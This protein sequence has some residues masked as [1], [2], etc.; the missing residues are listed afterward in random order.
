MPPSLHLLKRF[1]NK[2]V[3]QSAT[4]SIDDHNPKDYVSILKKTKKKQ[5]SCLFKK[6]YF[7]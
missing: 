7:I 2:K 5:V 4:N 1:L 3:L 6:N